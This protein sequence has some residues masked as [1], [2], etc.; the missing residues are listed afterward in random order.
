[1][2]ARHHASRAAWLAQHGDDALGPAV[3]IRVLPS[4][5][6][7]ERP[8]DR[9]RHAGSVDAGD[10]VAADVDGLG[11]LGAGPQRDARCRDRCFLRSPPESVN[12]ILAS[13]CSRPP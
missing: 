9:A 6:R 1:M 5:L 2:T 4:P 11:S 12:T 7:R 13:R 8:A 10:Q 3:A